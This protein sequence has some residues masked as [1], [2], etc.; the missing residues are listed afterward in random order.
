MSFLGLE[1]YTPVSLPL[2][3]IQNLYNQMKSLSLPFYHLPHPHSVMTIVTLLDLSTTLS[4]SFAKQQYLSCDFHPYLLIIGGESLQL[5]TIHVQNDLV[6]VSVSR[7]VNSQTVS[8][9]CVRNRYFFIYENQYFS[10]QYRVTNIN[11]LNDFKKAISNI[12]NFPSINVVVNSCLLLQFNF[13]ASSITTP[14]LLRL[15]NISERT[16]LSSFTS[17]FRYDLG[18]GTLCALFHDYPFFVW[19]SEYFLL[20]NQYPF[21]DYTPQ[22]RRITGG[23]KN[24]MIQFLPNSGMSSI[25]Y[26][27]LYTDH[28]QQN[29]PELEGILL[30]YTP[31]S[32]F[33][34]FICFPTQGTVYLYGFCAISDPANF[35]SIFQLSTMESNQNSLYFGSVQ[36]TFIQE[37]PPFEPPFIEYQGLEIYLSPEGF[38][39]I[40][41]PTFFDPFLKNNTP[42]RLAISDLIVS[43]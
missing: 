35:T 39:L 5:Y 3:F 7:Q 34:P 29:I 30:E 6:L 24:F 36:S 23:K 22:L 14:L 13:I 10:L 15:V 28:L 12:Y 42:T 20:L 32:S 8:T 31:L 21:L 37:R 41:E 9:L 38:F 19:N 26:T 1:S 11:R 40:Y 25:A 33:L 43:S 16:S 2:P 18:R 17:L 4:S 27:S